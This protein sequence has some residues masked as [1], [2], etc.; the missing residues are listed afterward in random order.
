M[1]AYRILEHDGRIR[2]EKETESSLHLRELCGWR[3]QS[4][5]SCRRAVS[6]REPRKEL[7]PL[8]IYGGTGLGIDSSHE[9]YRLCVVSKD[10]TKKVSFSTSEEF[11]NEMINAIRFDRMVD[12]AINTEM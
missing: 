2:I 9:C 10:K 1:T 12:F 7:H 11:T 3:L 8:F 4:V 6:F 5:R